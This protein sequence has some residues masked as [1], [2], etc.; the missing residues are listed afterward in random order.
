[1]A[2]QPAEPLVPGLA[3]RGLQVGT[4]SYMAPEVM[5]SCGANYDAKVGDGQAGAPPVSQPAPAPAYRPRQ[6]RGV[7]PHGLSASARAASHSRRA[8]LASCGCAPPCKEP[9]AATSG[10][11]RQADEHGACRMKQ[12]ATPCTMHHA[13]H[14][15]H[16]SGRCG[17]LAR[18]Q[19]ADVWSCG[20]VLFVM[21]FGSYPFDNQPGD[22]PG[23]GEAAKASRIRGP[24]HPSIHPCS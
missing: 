12:A 19:V 2:Q 16:T 1:M 18:A 14:T 21:L 7:K 10:R 5:K 20:V 9:R 24:T 3:W 15:A 4:L 8:A 23:L 11:P 22:D 6:G 13:P 17:V